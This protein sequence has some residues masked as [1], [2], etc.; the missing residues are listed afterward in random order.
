MPDRACRCTASASMLVARDRM[1]GAG[2]RGPAPPTAHEF[3]TQD[4][5]RTRDVSGIRGSGETSRDTGGSTHGTGKRTDTARRRAF[6]GRAHAGPLGPDD[7][8]GPQGDGARE[9]RAR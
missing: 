3:L 6:D 7:E 4:T 9:G 8:P 2:R 1:P 5:G